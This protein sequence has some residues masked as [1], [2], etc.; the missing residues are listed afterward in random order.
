MAQQKNAVA[1]MD[2]SGY[3]CEMR[4]L[5]VGAAIACDAEVQVNH[6]PTQA[7]LY[8][9]CCATMPQARARA[10]VVAL[11]TLLPHTAPEHGL[12]HRSLVAT[13]RTC[14][15]PWNLT[16]IFDDVLGMCSLA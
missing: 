13:H 16:I 7:S 4:D 12:P 2:G 3:G 14:K 9:P 15:W 1:G 8:G 5:L 11:H 10:P 6:W